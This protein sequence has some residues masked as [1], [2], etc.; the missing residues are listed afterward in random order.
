[1]WNIAFKGNVNPAREQQESTVAQELS[2]GGT[3]TRTPSFV[4]L[5]AAIYALTSPFVGHG[6]FSSPKPASTQQGQN[7]ADSYS[8]ARSS[9]ARGADTFDG[10]HG[11]TRETT[12]ASGRD[13][14]T[15]YLQQAKDMAQGTRD[16]G[17]QY[18]QQAPEVGSR[19]AQQ[20]KDSVMENAQNVK[21]TGGQY[22][23]QAREV[24]GQYYQQAQE[25]TAQYA[26]HA[27]DN[28]SQYVQ[29]AHEATDQA[30][31]TVQDSA[32]QIGQRVSDIS[33]NVTETVMHATEVAR[34]RAAAAAETGKEIGARAAGAARTVAGEGTRSVR[35]FG[36]LA[37]RMLESYPIARAFE[38]RTSIPKVYVAGFL[39]MLMS[40]AFYLHIVDLSGAHL[41]TNLIGLYPAVHALSAPLQTDRTRRDTE[42]KK[43]ITYFVTYSLFNLVEDSLW[44]ATL[45][46]HLPLWYFAKL[47]MLGWLGL[48]TFEG[49]LAVYDRV[50][51]P[52]LADEP[53][54]ITGEGQGKR[55]D[56]LSDE[57]RTG[58]VKSAQRGSSRE[59]TANPAYG[60]PEH[61][62]VQVG[63]KMRSPAGNLRKEE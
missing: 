43:W 25:T 55:D 15:S 18:M 9:A 35:Q 27:K 57:A 58:Y 21:G 41:L 12:D 59:G 45:L 38:E 34:E 46:R 16:S 30:L 36:A 11:P 42:S 61:P 6:D 37:D 56:D 10:T 22:V 13:T 8:L 23:Q 50:I 49:A 3:R 20:A 26:Q 52:Y 29:N 51:R 24:V 14:G 1:M 2:Q 40:V 17:A 60:V 28:G 62:T 31:H 7:T 19:Y 44:E 63:V 54:M 47:G 48:P 32:S 5:V 4:R 39:A 53:M 33:H